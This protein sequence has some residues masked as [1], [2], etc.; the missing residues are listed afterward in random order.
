[1][2]NIVLQNPTK[3]Y[4]ICYGQEEQDLQHSKNGRVSWRARDDDS[5]LD[6]EK[7]GDATTRLQKLSSIY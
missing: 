6:K 4:N 2:N 5:V 3:D 1:M 7:V